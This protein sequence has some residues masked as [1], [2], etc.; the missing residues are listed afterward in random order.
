M[1]AIAPITAVPAVNKAASQPAAKGATSAATANT[2]IPAQQTSQSSAPQDIVTVSS[3]AENA[4]QVL[5]QVQLLTQQGESAPEIAEQ[6][7]L[8]VQ[9]VEG[10]LG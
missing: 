5:S 3:N 2:Q 4:I 1:S 9:E 10:Y 7:G 6:L 8:S